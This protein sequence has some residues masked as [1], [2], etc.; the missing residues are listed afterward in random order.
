MTTLSLISRRLLRRGRIS[1]RAC[2]ELYRHGRAMQN[3]ASFDVAQ[4]TESVQ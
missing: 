1:D 3:A 4:V 2:G